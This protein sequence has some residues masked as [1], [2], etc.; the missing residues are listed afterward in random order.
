MW[1]RAF[2]TEAEQLRHLQNV[3]QPARSTRPQQNA[4]VHPLADKIQTLRAFKLSRTDPAE[5]QV[6]EGDFKLLTVL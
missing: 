6:S 2:R 5:F 1:H 4:Y 3:A